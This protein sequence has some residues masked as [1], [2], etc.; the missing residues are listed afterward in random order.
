MCVEKTALM[1]CV[2]GPSVMVAGL[3]RAQR[4]LPFMHWRAMVVAEASAE[5]MLPCAPVTGRVVGA[6]LKAGRR[7]VLARVVAAMAR[8]E[9]SFIVDLLLVFALV[10]LVEGI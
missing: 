6:A 7:V 3:L 5:T 8:R 4:S 10:R 2:E 1:E 9:V